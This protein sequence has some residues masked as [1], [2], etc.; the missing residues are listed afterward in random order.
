MLT[1]IP[2]VQRHFHSITKLGEGTFSK[3]Y[4]AKSLTDKQQ[5]A[6]KYIIP[7]VK[8]HRVAQ[9]LRFLRDVGG[10]QNNIAIK[11]CFFNNGHVVIIMPYFNSTAERFSDYV[12]DLNFEEIKDY[13]K[14]L[15]I[16]LRRVHEIGIIHRDVKPANFL[17]NRKERKYALVDFG[18]AQHVKDFRR[19]S[20]SLN[21]EKPLDLRGKLRVLKDSTTVNNVLV[22]TEPKQFTI[23]KRSLEE[24]GKSVIQ[25]PNKKMR[26]DYDQKSTVFLSPLTPS[27]MLT[28]KKLPKGLVNLSSPEIVIPETPQK[29]LQRNNKN[30]YQKTENS[31]LK[32]T[33]KS[34]PVKKKH[35][36]KEKTNKICACYGREYICKECTEKPEMQAPRAG[37]P[38][39]RAPEVLMKYL[40]QTTLIDIWSAGVIFACLL[41]GRYPFFRNTDDFTSLAEII[42]VFGTKRIE[43][44]AKDLNIT[45]TTSIKSKPPL[46]LQILCM[47]LRGS[48]EMKIPQSAFDLLD[49][50]M[51]PNPMTRITAKE[52]LQHPFFADES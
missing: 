39:F 42:T 40:Y 23:R 46:N 31:K 52:A 43:K 49:K 30:K 6:L 33:P 19:W 12:N 1:S 35:S 4:K 20:K 47:K 44:T 10:I 14:N 37:T 22:K 34:R 11:G 51:D 16:A 8:Q 29:V 28:P 32:E 25:A 26:V 21:I 45:L 13:I 48:H 24:L 9:E 41:C 18:L 27:V 38:G 5:Y 7:T 36:P 3:V 2:E 50:I 15:L 17:Y